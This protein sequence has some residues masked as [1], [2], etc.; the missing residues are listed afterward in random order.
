MVVSMCFTRA[1]NCEHIFGTAGMSARTVAWRLPRAAYLC[2]WENEVM[3]EARHVARVCSYIQSHDTQMSC[4]RLNEYR[5]QSKHRMPLLP[6]QHSCIIRPLLLESCLHEP[7][8]S[9]IWPL[10]PCSH[11]DITTFVAPLLQTLVYNHVATHLELHRRSQARNDVLVVL[12][13]GIREHGVLPR[14]NLLG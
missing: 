5:K 13:L 11:R 6:L 10:S 4:A 2:A 1:G 3:L 14:W 8:H 7:S 9:Q 12:G